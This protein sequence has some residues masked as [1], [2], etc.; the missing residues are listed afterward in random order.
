MHGFDEMNERDLETTALSGNFDAYEHLTKRH[1]AHLFVTAYALSRN[2]NTAGVLVTTTVSITWHQVKA[3][4]QREDLVTALLRNMVLYAKRLRLANGA[5][6][7]VEAAVAV[8]K[9]DGTAAS[10]KKVAYPAAASGEYVQMMRSN[11][12]DLVETLISRMSFEQS[13]I[14][15]LTYIAEQPIAEIAEYIS[16]TEKTASNRLDEMLD[17]M[18][19]EMGEGEAAAV[20]SYIRRHFS[21]EKEYLKSVELSNDADAAVQKGLLNAREGILPKCSNKKVWSWALGVSLGVVVLV[22]IVL[23]PFREKEIHASLNFSGT[24]VVPDESLIHR[25]PTSNEYLRSRVEDGDYKTL[26]YAMELNGGSRL[27]IDGAIDN[28]NETILWYTLEKD[29]AKITNSIVDG[30]ILDRSTLLLL[31]YLQDQVVL[32]STEDHEKGIVIF[33]RTNST[34]TTEGALLQFNIEV[35]GDEP[36]TVTLETD[37]PHEV[38]QPAKEITLDESFTIEGQTYYITG[39]TIS[40]DYTRVKIKPDI[41]NEKGIES[42]KDIR[43]DRV[44]ENSSSGSRV[45][46]ISGTDL[47]FPSI[48]YEDD[49]EEIQ[50]TL[51][52]ELFNLDTPLVIDINNPA[53]VQYPAGMKPESFGI[54][55]AEQPNHRYHTIQFPV[56]EGVQYKISDLYTDAGGNVY[57]AVA[58]IAEADNLNMLIPDL[59]YVQPLT[60]YFSVHDQDNLNDIKDLSNY[61]PRE[62]RISITLMKKPQN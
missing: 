44:R 14:F 58:K 45:A 36:H 17:A 7:A 22:I 43:L 32:E 51:A 35:E 59:N 60:F 23:N 27:I 21:K 18:A 28:G 40:S 46:E 49:Y 19:K 13:V 39:L 16:R 25:D 53:L 55:Y 15:L 61:D 4:K 31:G 37:Y 10:L 11:Q 3:G 2:K 38:E 9:P 34:V 24:R 20:S 48:Y 33:N 42:L 47:I 12:A 26:G 41:N 56:W 5:S 1:A 62:G 8:S 57:T 6:V 29:D 50:L 30:S 52:E 54:T